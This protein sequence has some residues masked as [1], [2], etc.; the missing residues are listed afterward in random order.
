MPDRFVFGIDFAVV[1]I[2]RVRFFTKRLDQKSGSIG[3]CRWEKKQ[4]I[5][6]DYYSFISVETTHN[7]DDIPEKEYHGCWQC[8]KFTTFIVFWTVSLRALLYRRAK[9][10]R[11]L[12]Q[13]VYWKSK[14]LQD[15]RAKL[16]SSFFLVTRIMQVLFV[17]RF[18]HLNKTYK[19]DRLIH[20]SGSKMAVKISSLVKNLMY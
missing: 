12:K 6:S 2:L 4:C 15:M 14:V 11:V 10:G 7:I 16:C 1:L 17:L 9:W 19:I 3:F 5:Q 20:D 13:D 8:W 18:Y